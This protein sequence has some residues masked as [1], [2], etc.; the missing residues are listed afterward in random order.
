M[1]RQQRH[2]S[3]AASRCALQASLSEEYLECVAKQQETLRPF[4]DIP[5]DMKAKVIRAFVTARS[6]VQGLAVSGEVVRRVSQVSVRSV[7]IV[8]GI[9]NKSN[10]NSRVKYP[11]PEK[12]RGFLMYTSSSSSPPSFFCFLFLVLLSSFSSKAVKLIFEE[13]QRVNGCKHQN[14]ANPKK[15]RK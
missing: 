12:L 4:G 6:F 9:N 5:R 7:T 1:W 11:H 3:P 13:S 10:P 14:V 2:H 15:R 8:P